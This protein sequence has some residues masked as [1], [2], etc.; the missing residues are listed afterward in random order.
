MRAVNNAKYLRRRIDEM[1]GI[2]QLKADFGYKTDVTKIFIRVD[3]LSGKRLESILEIDFG[4]EVESASDIGI[5]V[6][7]NIGN[8]RADM[9]YLADCLDIITQKTQ[10]IIKSMLFLYIVQTTRKEGNIS[11]SGSKPIF[12]HKRAAD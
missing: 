7:S 2:H 9:A 4:I 5:L 1:N 6:L 3:G 10:Y 8:S 11:R 12:N